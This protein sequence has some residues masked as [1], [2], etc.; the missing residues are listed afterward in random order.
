[1]ENDICAY[2]NC[3]KIDDNKLV[4]YYCSSFSCL[5]NP[6]INLCKEHR[7]ESPT[8]GICGRLEV[9]NKQDFNE[10]CKYIVISRLNQFVIVSIHIY[11]IYYTFWY[12]IHMNDGNCLIVHKDTPMYSSIYKPHII[13]TLYTHDMTDHLSKILDKYEQYTYKPVL[14]S[15]YFNISMYL[16]RL[17]RDITLIIRTYL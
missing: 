17:P 14:D 16:N 13:A 3:N 2:P 7:G 6:K 10:K 8:V 9:T 1:M 12:F 11:C 4:A 15:L 5:H